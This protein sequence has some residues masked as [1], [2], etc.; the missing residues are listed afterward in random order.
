M[1]VLLRRKVLTV[2]VARS[3]EWK[4]R[5]DRNPHL[6]AYLE[7]W[8]KMNFSEPEFYVQL[9]RDMA[10]IREPNVIY[11]VGDPV[12]IHVYTQSDGSKI[13]HPIEPRLS[14][15]ERELLLEEVEKR[16]AMYINEKMIPETKEEH[17]KL[18]Y[19]LLDKVVEISSSTRIGKRG[20]VFVSKDT[21][22]R[23]K[24]ELYCEKIGVSILEPFIR[25]PYIEDIHC[26]GVGPMYIEHKI[27]GRLESTVKFEN[28]KELDKFIIKLSE[29]IGKPVSYRNPIVDATLPD[30]SRINIVFGEDVSRRGSNFTIRKFSKK[31]L[32]ITQLIKF[33]TMDT[34]IAAYLWMLLEEGMSIWV[35]GE[36]ASGKTTTLNAM[37]VFIKPDIKVVSIEDTPEVYLPHPNWAREVV[38][39][40]ESSG[41]GKRGITMFDLLKAALRQRPRYIIV[42]EVRGEEG[43]IAFQA[44]QTGHP[45]LATFHAASVTK[46]IQ[47]LTGHPIN[48]P[49]TYID[50]LNAVIIQSAVHDPETGKY[51]RRVLS[52]NEI[53]GYNP[54]EQ[55]FEFIEVF[56]WDPATDTFLFR[57]L[58]SSYLL[59]SKIALLKGIPSYEIKRVYDELELR[60]KVLDLIVKA[61]IFDYFEVWKIIKWIYNVGLENA[62]PKLERMAKLK[63]SG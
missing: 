13:Y 21:Y 56:S 63:G 6:A 35:S 24:Y 49:K 11:P 3:K 58:G 22:E 10:S 15:K 41:Q 43:R 50:N 19:S 34:R 47:R 45:V 36:T 20:K 46:L 52:V 39:E 55:S 38:R 12:Y 17:E 32:S 14:K 33:G 59:E 7:K 27:F 28:S 29:I 4:I 25:D 54:A 42:G 31:P 30:G 62:L 37:A 51:K 18:L 44:M 48:V 16:L 2:E 9:S 53:L 1:K 40:A 57:G 5:I 60:K 26:S 61:E 23:L 8:R